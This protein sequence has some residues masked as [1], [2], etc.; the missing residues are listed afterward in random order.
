ML[1][2]ILTIAAAALLNA[3][4]KQK[5]AIDFTDF[6]NTP[7]SYILQFTNSKT[8]AVTQVNSNAGFTQSAMLANG[9]YTIELIKVTGA[10]C[11]A[12]VKIAEP[13]TTLSE[14]NAANVTGL[15][16]S[17]TVFLMCE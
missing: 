17:Y 9:T 4:K 16:N 8:G 3:G 12:Y 13:S 1:F 11:P 10:S 2:E 14:G 6:T 7:A 15:L 5:I